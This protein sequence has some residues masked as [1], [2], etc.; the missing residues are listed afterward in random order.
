[1]SSIFQ[2]CITYLNYPEPAL[3]FSVQLCPPSG[4]VHLS[5]AAMEKMSWVR[6][7]IN[8][9]K[10]QINKNENSAPEGDSGSEKP[11]GRSSARVPQRIP[12]PSLGPPTRWRQLWNRALEVVKNPEVVDSSPERKKLVRQGS[13]S[14]LLGD[15]AQVG[16]HICQTRFLFEFIY[17]F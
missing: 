2:N 16:I 14:S 11:D 5:R 8:K 15:I 10:K 6:C 12:P 1:M 3:I 4:Q 9:L 7:Q 13:R 17:F